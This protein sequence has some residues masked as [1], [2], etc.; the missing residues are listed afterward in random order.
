MSALWEN[1]TVIVCV[2]TGGVGKTTVAAAMGVA[3]ARR[4]RRTLVMTI[5][6]ARRLANALGLD[7][8][9]SQ[10]IEVDR[11][12]L[13]AA[14]IELTAP[15]SIL[16]P[17]VRSVF[18]ELVAKVAPNAAVRER[19]YANRMYQSFASMLAGSLEYA[20]VEKLY[21][22]VREGRYDLVILDTPPSQNAATFLDA[23]TRVVDFMQHDALRWL[24]RP[25]MLAGKLSARLL[26]F[27]SNFVF[28][29]LGRFAGAD[30]LRELADFVLAFDGLYDGFYERARAVQRLLRDSSLA[31]VLVA[32]PA[33]TQRQAALRFAEELRAQGLAPKAL[34]LNRVRPPLM[35]LTPEAIGAHFGALRSTLD[36]EALAGLTHAAHDEVVLATRDAQAVAAI[37]SEHPALVLLTLPEL[38]VDVHELTSLGELAGHFEARTEP[39]S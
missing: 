13:E 17:E 37:R 14:G 38:A 11:Q 34:I 25:Y 12:H 10:P 39:R 30:T 15:L 27:G 3:A 20:A 32:A 2:G 23:P 5:D 33:P 31:F 29:T 7:D 24:L 19:I 1:H 28:R 16:M 18:D 35:A 36:P 26:D 4:G 21:D 9:T 22:V 6:P 8:V